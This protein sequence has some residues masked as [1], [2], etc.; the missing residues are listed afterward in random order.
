MDG[1]PMPEQA[2][3]AAAASFLGMWTVMMIGMMLPAAVPMLAR[4]R[5]A[6]APSGAIRLGVLTAVAGAGY[7]LAWAAAGVAAFPLDAALMS[8]DTH[9]PAMARTVPF[10]TGAVVVIA[11]ALQFTTW[12]ARH[13]ACCRELPGPGTALPRDAGTAWRHGLRLGLHCIYCSAGLMAI[14]LVT[15]VMEVRGMVLVAGAIAAE[16]LAP[17]GRVAARALG[18]VIVA[19][20]LLMIARAAWPA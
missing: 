16:R 8:A 19:A 11:G 9:A 15:G 5:A 12:K 17:D 3:P 10:V 4:Y 18:A 20:G 1:M 13:L 7:F 6:V 14:L 2:W